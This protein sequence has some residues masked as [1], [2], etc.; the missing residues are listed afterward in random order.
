[1][2]NKITKET[3]LAEL[4]AN[5][6]AREIMAKYDLPCLSCPFAQMEMNKLKIGDICKM[7]NIDNKALLRDLNKIK[8]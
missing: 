6:K 3:I 7:Y 4:L 8:S 2:P 5:P 1:M